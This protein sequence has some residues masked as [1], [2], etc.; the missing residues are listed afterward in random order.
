MNNLNW[1]KP[2]SLAW[3]PNGKLVTFTAM[4]QAEWTQYVQIIDP[5]GKPISFT[6]LDGQSNQFPIEG[7]G[8]SVGFFK[9]GSGK[10]YMSEGLQ[11]QFANSG[12]GETLVEAANPTQFFINGQIFGGGT[13]FVTEDQGGT[14]YND[15]SFCIE[16][17]KYEG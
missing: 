2:M 14:D 11:I 10:F 9:N 3:I 1:S 12:S 13:L 7:Q 17:Y 5:S 6:T 8:I 15:T 4:H 16:W